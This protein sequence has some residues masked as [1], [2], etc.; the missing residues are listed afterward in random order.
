MRATVI[1]HRGLHSILA[2]YCRASWAAFRSL[3]GGP[4]LPIFPSKCPDLAC[5]AFDLTFDSSQLLQ[6]AQYPHCQGPVPGHLCPSDLCNRSREHCT[7]SSRLQQWSSVS[8][9]L[10]QA[11]WVEVCSSILRICA[12]LAVSV[13]GREL[14]IF[15]SKHWGRRVGNKQE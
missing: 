8:P 12:D 1:R 14:I 2:V 13:C 9:E 11:C 15:V 5:V 10:W 4:V 7:S 3:Y 6:V